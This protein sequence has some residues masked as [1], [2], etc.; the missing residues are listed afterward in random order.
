MLT[1]LSLGATAES[2]QSNG[3]RVKTGCSRHCTTKWNEP[4][5]LG[6]RPVGKARVTHI[7]LN[8]RPRTSLTLTLAECWRNSAVLLPVFIEAS[9]WWFVL[10]LRWVRFKQYTASR[11]APHFEFQSRLRE[12]GLVSFMQRNRRSF[13]TALVFYKCCKRLMVHIEITT[14][15]AG[16]HFQS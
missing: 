16:R 8:R 6:R 14:S 2:M 4:S 1:L 7:H 15:I 11:S 12:L 9:N 13:P 5:R 3:W 10:D